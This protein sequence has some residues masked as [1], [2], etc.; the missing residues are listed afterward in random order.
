MILN[1]KQEPVLKIFPS[2]YTRI[3]QYWYC[4][5][6]DSLVHGMHAMELML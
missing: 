4:M 5:Y 1:G 2:L 6:V 3:V